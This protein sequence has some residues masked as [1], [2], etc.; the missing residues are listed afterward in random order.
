M[1]QRA[2][3]DKAKLWSHFL[4]DADRERRLAN[5]SH[6]VQHHHPTALVLHP[7]FK[8]QQFLIAAIEGG[9]IESLSPVGHT[10]QGPIYRVRSRPQ[11]RFM[12]VFLLLAT[13]LLLEQIIEPGIIKKGL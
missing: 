13:L 10:P 3:E 12:L 6:A 5:A 7:L 9:D 11:S 8:S 1:A 2:P 4:G